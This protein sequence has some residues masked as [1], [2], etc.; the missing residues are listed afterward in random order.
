MPAADQPDRAG[1]HRADAS[2]LRVAVIAYGLR[3]G[4]SSSLAGWSGSGLLG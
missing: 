1:Q 2:G 3:H 4:S